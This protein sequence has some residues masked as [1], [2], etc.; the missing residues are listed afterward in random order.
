MID[1]SYSTT[2]AGLSIGYFSSL[3]TYVISVNITP[4]PNNIMVTA[5][6]MNYGYVKTV[7]HIL[8]IAFGCLILFSLVALGLGN[9]FLAYPLLHTGLKIIGSLYLLWL[10]YKIFTSGGVDVEGETSKPTT[11]LQALTFQFVNPKAWV[12]SIT[13]VSAFSLKGDALWLSLIVVVMTQFLLVFPCSSTWAL[14]GS[15]IKKIM[16]SPKAAKM[17]NR[18][19]GVLTASCVI[20]I[21][22]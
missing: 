2:Y 14:L 3:V 5:S 12:M 19:L 18:V 4:G 13:A 10:A 15:Q 16:R 9:I 6:G 11:F 1:P 20:F 8:G 7:P 21:V 17:F 22:N